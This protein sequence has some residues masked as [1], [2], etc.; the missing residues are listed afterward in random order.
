MATAVPERPSV[1]S[2][3]QINRAAHF[4]GGRVRARLDDL[5]RS[6]SVALWLWNGFPV[7]ARPM[8]GHVFSRG[9]AGAPRGDHLGIGGTAGGH[10][11]RLVVSDGEQLVGGRS[12][13]GLREWHHV[14]LV[15][16]GDRVRVHLDGG[17]EPDLEAEVPAR[18][19]EKTSEVFVGGR[20]DGVAG[21]EGKIDEVAVFG[22]PLGPAEIGRLHA[23]AG[24]ERKGDK[25]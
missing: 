1:F 5:P 12:L 14:V 19:P 7:D 25:P 16:D 13:L 6:Y 22:R 23:A 18:W 9:A 20:S 15:R 10:A 21:F 2:G 3:P 4:A 24:R 11:G 8:T 17:C